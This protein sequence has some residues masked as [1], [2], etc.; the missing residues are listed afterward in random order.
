MNDSES[1]VLA[2]AVSLSLFAGYA[3][4]VAVALHRARRSGR[5]GPGRDGAP[6]GPPRETVTSEVKP[7]SVVRA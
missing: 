1:T 7:R 6:P 4:R 3:I 2:Y 5:R